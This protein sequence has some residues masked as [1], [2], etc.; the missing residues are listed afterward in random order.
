MADGTC[1][2]CA[3]VPY[4]GGYKAECTYPD[5]EEI[6]DVRERPFKEFSVL[7]NSS[8]CRNCPKNTGR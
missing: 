7:F 8:W 4:M 5:K 2:Y 1:K 3:V 6:D